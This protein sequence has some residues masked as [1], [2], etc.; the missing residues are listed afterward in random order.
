MER[1]V[2]GH[3]RRSRAGWVGSDRA[4]PADSPQPGP[5]AGRLGRRLGAAALDMADWATLGLLVQRKKLTN[6]NLEMQ[7]SSAT[8]SVTR[9][10]A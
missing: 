3:T 1:G 2:R 10:A 6:K 5:G 8:S 4:G 7:A 9:R